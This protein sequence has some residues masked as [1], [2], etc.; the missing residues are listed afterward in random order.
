LIGRQLQ[1]VLTFN[2][3][4]TNDYRDDIIRIDHYFNDKVHFYAAA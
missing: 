2:Q 3:P 4:S 1:R